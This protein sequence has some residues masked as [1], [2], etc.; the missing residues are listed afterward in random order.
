[1]AIEYT[2]TFGSSENIGGV[3][4][5]SVGFESIF[6][7]SK[8]DEIISS[9]FSLYE[10]PLNTNQKVINVADPQIL[11]DAWVKFST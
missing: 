1:M 8:R 10:T 4:Y 9:V 6:P 11:L 2:G 7:E 3:V 5:L